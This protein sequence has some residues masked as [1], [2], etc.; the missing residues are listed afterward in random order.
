V[1]E[2]ELIGALMTHPR[3]EIAAALI[4]VARRGHRP[5]QVLAASADPAASTVPLLRDRVALDGRATAYVCRA[6]ACRRP[7]TQPEELAA[8]LAGATAAGTEQP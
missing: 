5:W 2:N 7:V 8:Q 3:V 1:T 4:G 6:F